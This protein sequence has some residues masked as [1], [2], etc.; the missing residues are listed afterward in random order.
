MAG[1]AS[2]KDLQTIQNGLVDG[3]ISADDLPGPVKDKVFQ[4]MGSQGV[5]MS[6]PNS[7]VTQAQLNALK[8]QRDAQEGG[9][10]DSKI[11]KPIEW[12]GSKL[13]QAYSATISPAVS[14]AGFQIAKFGNLAGGDYNSY[15]NDG[16]DLAFSDEWD[17]AHH[18]SPGQSIWRSFLSKDQLK[19]SGLT[20]EEMLKQAKEVEA[21]T[22]QAEKT[23]DDP[24]G[25]ETNLEKYF[26]QGAAKYVSGATDFAISW[27]A[28][29][30]VIGGKVLGGLKAA[31]VTRPV[32]TS[33][34]AEKAALPATLSVEDANKLAWDNFSKK[35]P[36]QSLTDTI[37]N[38]KQANP[39]TAA[40]RLNRDLPTLA[41]SANGPAAA[42][43]LAQATD[44]TEV[45]N[46]LRVTMGD[47]V[48]NQAL[49]VQNSELAY[50]IEQL[51]N[52][53]STVATYY[54]GLS[55]AEKASPSGIRTKSLMDAQSRDMARLDRDTQMV[56]DKINAFGTIGALN[57]NKWTTSA[58][59][60]ARN[61]WQ[62]SRTWQPFEDGGFIKTQ[63]NNIYSLSLGGMVK[64]AHTYNDIKPSHYIDVHDADSYKQ[65]NASLMDVKGLTPEARDMYVSQYLQAS[66]A[67]KPA[68]LQ[69]IEQKVTRNMVD[70][71]NARTGENISHEVADSLY[72][73]V[74][75]KRGA[76]QGSMKSEQFGT[77]QIENPN[78][79][80]TQIRVDE[81]TPD[82]SKVIVT[83][84]LRTQL[85]NNHSMLDF[86][87]FE[88]ALNANA[89]SW[90][91]A[92]LTVGNGWEKAVGVADYVN[93]IWKFSQLAR[94]GYG[95]RA[96]SD[97]ALGQLA[98]FGPMSIMDRAIKGGKYTW[99]GL[100]RAAFPDNYFEAANVAKE[101]LGIH[102][103]D[104][105]N[106]QNRIQRDIDVARREGRNYDVVAHKDELNVNL[107]M[108]ND[109]R[110]KYADMD[111]LVKGGAAMK[112]QQIGR[113]IF[114]PA[115]AGAEGGLFRDL[116]SGEKNF[117]NMMGGAS[118]SYLNQLRRLDWTQLSPAKHGA[119]VHMNAWLKVLNQQVAHDALASQYLKGKTSQQLEAW[120]RSPDGLAYK[121]DHT[122]AK[123]LPNDQLVDRVTAQIDE[124]ANPAFPGGDVIRKAAAEGKVTKEMLGEV[125]EIA[126]PLVNGQ[127]LS[128]AR[129]SHKAIQLMDKAMDSWYNLASAAPAR[130]LLR[131]PLFAQRYKV[132][133]K[134]MMETSGET[135]LTEDLRKQFESA[136]RKRALQDVKKNTF[137]MDYETKMSYMLRN[138]GAFFGAQQE[139]WNRWGRIISDKPDILPRIAQVMGAPTR[140]GITTNADG[141]R[142]D[143]DGYA[144]DPIT[145]ERHLVPY[146]DRHIVIQIPDWLGG[147]RLSKIMG[148]GGKVAELDK[149]GNVKKDKHGNI[150]YQQEKAT[151]DIPMSTANI[152]LNHG[153]GPLPVSAGPY[154]QIAAQS[155]LPGDMKAES[156][157]QAADFFQKIGILPFG[158]S[159]SPLSTFLPNWVRKAEDGSNTMGEAYQQNLWYIMQ[160]ETYKYNEGLRKTKPG[161]DEIID[162]ADKQTRMKVLF[163]AVLPIS[164]TAKDPY[165]FFRDQYKA[166]QAADPDNAD[167][168][169]YDKF[170]DSAYIFS[171]SLSKNNSGL[172]PT[173]NAVKMSKHYQD[174][175]TKVG[176]EWAGLVVGAEGEGTYSNGA[177]HYEQTHATDPASGET[178]RSKM[179]A[180]EALDNANLARGWEQYNSEMNRIYSELYAGG[181]TS[182]DDPGAEHIKS[183]KQALVKVLSSPQTL[184][185][186]GELVNNP[187]YNE[188]WSKA[189]NS[190]DLNY[191]DR[192]AVQLK[193]IVNDPEI[194]SKA[195]NPDG[196][197]GMRSDIYTLKT[198][199]AYR[200]DAKAALLLR[201]NGGGSDDITAA[202][203]ADIKGQWDSMVNSLI[204]NDTKFGDLFNRYLSRDM[205]YDKETVQQEAQTGSLEQFQG[206]TDAS[207]Q[208]SEQQG[209]QSI[210]DVLAGQGLIT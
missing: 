112:H 31:K 101:N 75:A 67:M 116:A 76:M 55:D 36:F 155:L 84:L 5:D 171:K 208:A 196:S 163:A 19:K 86:K 9:I 99:E 122:I 27:Y 144:T 49:K 125:P 130:Y 167:Q 177:F 187:Y 89:S 165:E 118:D 121:A 176:P 14:F 38:I 150:I 173:A 52:R 92:M 154:V 104:L 114:S 189:Y 8:A 37:W 102:I 145:G 181:F 6:D 149:D 2:P 108:L 50:Q 56:S 78:L 40:A 127:A 46:I 58:G 70:R 179:S 26:G 11:F 183:E 152:I 164:L 205:G 59:I 73:E 34:K 66:D 147:Q 12:V 168:L 13:Y 146:N 90:N 197:V 96:L 57:Y 61:A 209:S 87:L 201:K 190:F 166:M 137:T 25:T 71:Y 207:A 194:W 180:R 141:E 110:Q 120:L 53:Q 186:N 159:D 91:K 204:Q 81:I 88:K 68:I 48:A 170:G 182:F 210:F 115:Y 160:A 3:L 202:S 35:Q 119:D 185:E 74:A 18:I 175:I 188:A 69:T 157:P 16:N 41:K 143:A 134:D 111:A 65:L 95:P 60:K 42:R 106:Q 198:Y 45:A 151:F 184:N 123:H 82:G 10:F 161:W 124:W 7:E 191:Y 192:T 107:D 20:E 77:A 1:N 22:F 97:D 83:P 203:N 29:P 24:F 148:S 44:K 142:I 136:A 200:D 156:N 63:V 131:N 126:R 105:V 133:L 51:S 30:T 199:L 153:D 193:Q 139:S 174:L 117:Q 17:L 195:V 62:Q 93:Q 100:R 158:V 138:F 80:G 113:Q 169:F 23:K 206:S 79:P 103:Q 85:A 15:I 172:Q 4:Y 129:G 98:R 72:R 132:Y 43:L 178:Y 162:R 32:S 39:D 28:D 109:V 64:L 33:I 54:N 128:Y 21:G 47:T 140:A 94:L 135:H